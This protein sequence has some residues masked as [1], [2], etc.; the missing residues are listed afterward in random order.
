MVKGNMILVYEFTGTTYNQILS[1]SRRI[2]LKNAYRVLLTRAR[3]GMVIFI[4]KGD[5][6][7]QSRKHEYYDG[8]FEYLKSIGIKELYRMMLSI[9]LS[10][11][12]RCFEFVKYFLF[13]LN[14]SFFEISITPIDNKVRRD[15]F[16]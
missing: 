6:V 7:D 10:I 3:Q 9:Y 2:Y 12:L 14:F 15:T 5:D 4:P 16:K 1:E 11:I 13:S 8:T